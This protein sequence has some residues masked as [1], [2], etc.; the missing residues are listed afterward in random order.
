[1]SILLAVKQ[2]LRNRSVQP[3]TSSR[4]KPGPAD[5]APIM[6]MPLI[7]HTK[8]TAGY[9][10]CTEAGSHCLFCPGVVGGR[11]WQGRSVVIRRERRD[12]EGSVP[13][14]GSLRGGTGAWEGLRVV[15]S[16]FLN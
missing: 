2:T 16:H 3:L 10:T 8:P 9:Q 15:A 7:R 6:P 14:L 4:I 11:G 12:W 5:S 13:L 1:M